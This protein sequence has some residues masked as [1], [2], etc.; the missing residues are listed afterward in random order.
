MPFAVEIVKKR[1][2]NRGIVEFGAIGTLCLSFRRL[3]VEKGKEEFNTN[4]HITNP[5]V[6][7]T[8]LRKYFKLSGV[9]YERVEPL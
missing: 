7:L 2:V 4:I 3:I 6:R 5:V 1:V 9:C 8:P